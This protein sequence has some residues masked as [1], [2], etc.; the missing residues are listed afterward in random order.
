[1]QEMRPAVTAQSRA[2]NVRVCLCLP[3]TATH[4]YVAWLG[5][6]CVAHAMPCGVLQINEHAPHA[7][8]VPDADAC[9]GQGRGQGQRKATTRFGAEAVH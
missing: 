1:M 6:E 4:V 5:L 9:R 8:C 7:T 3:A 2:S